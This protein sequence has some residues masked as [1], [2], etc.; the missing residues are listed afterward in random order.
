M[1]T[2]TWVALLRGINVGGNK[3]VAMADLRGLLESLGYQEVRTVLQSGNARFVAAG[4]SSTLETQ[5]G[6]RIAADLGLDVK[7]LVRSADEFGAVVD[8]NPWPARGVDRKELH[9]AFL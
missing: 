3:R 8:A 7:V 6:S 9:V 2:R 5:I 1:G 4:P